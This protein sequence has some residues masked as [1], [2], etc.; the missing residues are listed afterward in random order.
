MAYFDSTSRTL[1]VSDYRIS[2][3][4]ESASP[5]LD[6]AQTITVAGCTLSVLEA[7]WE[8]LGQ[9]KLGDKVTL[10][11]TDD[12]KVA[13]ALPVSQLSTDM[14]GILSTDGSHVTLCSSGLVLSAKEV[15]ADE[16]LWGTLVR[17]NV[18]QDS[19]SCFA[20]SST[21]TGKLDIS[22]RTLGRY[23]LAPACRIYEHAGNSFNSS[24]VHSLSGEIGVASTDFDDIFWT[25]ILSA[26]K[27]DAVHL[28][29][30][31]QVDL[32]LL[33]NVT[34]NCYSYG[35]LVR[36]SGTDGIMTASSPKPTYNNAVT[37]T[38][39]TGTSQ[40]YLSAHSVPHNRYYGILL[41]RYSAALEEVVSLV[42][43]TPSGHLEH[44]AFF[45]KGDDWFVSVNGTQIPVS[46]QVQ[47]YIDPTDQWLS[48]TDGV[49]TAISSGLTLTTHYDKTLTTGAVAR[50]IVAEK[51]K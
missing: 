43:L 23:S 9:F 33:K 25:T 30:A 42:E 38:N 46:E 20:Y 18:Y 12:L 11:L 15:D 17:V 28:N 27:V 50:V 4:I 49:R 32:I 3:C 44:G 34:E 45:L 8:S 6:A 19:I 16:H 7:A 5:T 47:V 48:G 10:L 51:I 35:K 2:A 14:L 29:S 37:L 39:A 24:Y 21:L 22:N 13:A 36:Y 26:D 1:C 41:R 40:K 31:G